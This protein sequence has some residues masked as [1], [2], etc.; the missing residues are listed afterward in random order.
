MFGGSSKSDQAQGSSAAYL[1]SS[2]WVVGRGNANGGGLSASGGLSFPWYGWVCAGVIA[3][4]WVKYRGK[5]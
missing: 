3:L 2:G 5:K 4:A 1:N